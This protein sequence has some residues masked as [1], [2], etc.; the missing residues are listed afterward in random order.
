MG[1]R[2]CVL[3]PKSW[4]CL[5]SGGLLEGGVGALAPALQAIAVGGPHSEG[6][7]KWLAAE[8][9]AGRKYGAEVT[10]VT[11]ANVHL[12]QSCFNTDSSSTNRS[13]SGLTTTYSS[14]SMCSNAQH[15]CHSTGPPTSYCQGMVMVFLAYGMY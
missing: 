2:N 12:Q 9:F 7:L 4:T 15:S 6:V 3:L 13:R 11:V 5:A 8:S 10:E 14:P 1:P